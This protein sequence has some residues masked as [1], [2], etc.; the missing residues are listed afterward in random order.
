MPSSVASQSSVR[1]DNNDTAS[2][3]G[4]RTPPRSTARTDDNNNMTLPPTPESEMSTPRQSPAT[5]PVLAARDDPVVPPTPANNS[6]DDESIRSELTPI[7]MLRGPVV[8]EDADRQP[9]PQAPEQSDEDEWAGTAAHIRGTD[10]HVPT[11][12]A[13]FADFLRNFVSLAHARRRQQQQQANRQSDDDESSVDSLMMEEEDET[14]LY[15]SKL[16]AMIQ[17]GTLSGTA[18]LDIDTQHLFFYSEAS[19]R[20]YH[21]LVAYP[22]EVVPLMDL[23]VQ[24]E[25]QGRIEQLARDQQDYTALLRLQVRPFNLKDTCNLRELDPVAMDSLVSI[26]G[27]IVRTSPVIPDLKVAYF[28]C[29]IC[30]HGQQVTIDRG[31][32]AEPT[33]AC[34][35]CQ[36]KNSHSLVHNRSVFAD[37]QLVRLQETPD[38]VPAGQTPASVLTFCFDD[39]V[40][41]VQ[42][43]D[44]VEVTGVL[45]AQPVRVHPR[46]STL[47]SIYKTYVDVIHYRTVNGLGTKAATGRTKTEFSPARVEQLKALAQRPDIYDQ[48]TSS[49][50]PSIWELD[51][52]KKG[53]LCMLVGGNH[54]DGPT[55]RAGEDEGSNWLDEDEE[56]DDKGERRNKKRAD[57]NILLCGDPGTSKSQL[58]SYV[59]KLSTRGVYTSGKGS[60]A[61]GLTAS[62]VRDPETKDLVLESGALVLSD[63]GICCIDEL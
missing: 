11:A 7:S 54:G 2:P 61:V 31:R 20:L 24:R 45:R 41:A 29:A 26:K 38:K 51:D 50:A 23:V 57:I 52:V 17:R 25:I 15:L 8:H 62:V 43:G 55:E 63:L 14:P 59:H 49:L 46:M 56:M 47:K 3:A 27:M 28:G 34:P 53:V 22:L 42:P 30:G 1:D 44:K 12:A 33:G 9:A 19:Q 32:I 58:L 13:A 5:S 37:K 10:I 21:Q 48:L 16:D 36:T 40:D 6:D 39:L 60:S 18:S 35:V 4:L